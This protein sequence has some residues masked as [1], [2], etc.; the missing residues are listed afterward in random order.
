MHYVLQ[1][2]L[3]ALKSGFNQI[4]NN[5]QAT[6]NSSQSGSKT[7]GINIPPSQESTLANLLAKVISLVPML[8]NKLMT[9][10]AL[11]NEDVINDDGQT[12]S[13][14]TIEG[15]LTNKYPLFDI[16]IFTDVEEGPRSGFA[17]NIKK[18]AAVWYIAIR[19]LAIVGCV[20][21][22][23]YIGIRL[24]VATTGESKAE[25]KKMLTSWFIGLILLFCM[26]YIVIIMIRVSDIFI[27]FIRTAIETDTNTTGMETFVLTN[28]FKNINN[29]DGWNKLFYLVLYCVM[30]YYEIKFF[31]MY[32]FRVF[33]VFIMMVISPLVCMTYSIDTVGDGRAQAFNN[34]F[35]RIMMEIFVQPIHL[36]IYVIFIYSAGEIA[37]QVPLIAIFFLVALDNA[38]KIIRSALKIQ[39][40][41]LRDIKLFGKGK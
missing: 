5:G 18:Q 12:L 4:F 17:N 21:V 7:I 33:K 3:Q 28:V 15:L 41:G 8:L 13:I 31:I 16:D 10:V 38:E 20:I 36:L 32:L 35:R 26:H 1:L 6:V 30:T 34:W 37:K 14:F 22:A 40:E 19:N 11:D 23:V 2:K 9:L 27:N 24:A 29:A 25:Y 39:G